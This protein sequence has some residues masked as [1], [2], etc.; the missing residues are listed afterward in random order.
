M[1][2]LVLPKLWA[3]FQGY[4]LGLCSMLYMIVWELGH[5]ELLANFKI[6]IQIKRKRIYKCFLCSVGPIGI[7]HKNNWLKSEETKLIYI[8]YSW[9]WKGAVREHV[10]TKANADSLKA[11]LRRNSFGSKIWGQREGIFGGQNVAKK[12]SRAFTMCHATSLCL[13]KLE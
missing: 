7:I 11:G 9:M 8:T 1:L 5:G 2:L 6:F 12:N 13:Q 4:S 10:T 3:P